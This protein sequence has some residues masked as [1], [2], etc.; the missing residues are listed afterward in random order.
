MRSAQSLAKS[1]LIQELKQAPCADCLR[2][3][4]SCVM[5]FDHRIAAEKHDIVSR[6]S[7]PDRILTEASKC[8]VVCS[9][10][11]QIRTLLRSQ[12]YDIKPK[13]IVFN[14]LVLMRSMALILKYWR[15]VCLSLKL[16]NNISVTQPRAIDWTSIKKMGWPY[17]KAHT[18]RLMF[19]KQFASDPFPSCH[20]FTPYK[21][22]HPLWRLEDVEAYF[23]S[24]GL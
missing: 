7:S 5:D 9:N 3:F 6:I 13:H 1:K 21:N 20:K 14:V 12:G 11:H 17:S 18:W 16:G 23:K 24:H 10:C 19:D 22:S 2:V 8:D 15:I 4:P